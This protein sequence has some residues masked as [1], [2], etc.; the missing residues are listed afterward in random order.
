MTSATTVLVVNML[1]FDATA[2]E[3]LDRVS[4]RLRIV[5]RVG[6]EATTDADIDAEVEGIIGYRPPADLRRTPRLRW[7]QVGSSG[8]DHVDAET[9]SGTR[10]A[11]TNASGVHAVPMGEYV[12]A[13]LLH[14]AQDV[15]PR[16]ANQRARA[17]PEHQ[18]TLAGRLLRGKTLVILGYGSIGREVG[19]LAHGFGMRI[20]AVKSDPSTRVDHGYVYPGTGD[21]EGRYP[22][23]FVGIDALPAV[24][25][26]ADYVVSAL[27]GTAASTGVVSRAVIGAMRP[28]A[29][30][31]NVGRGSAVDEDAL[32]EALRERRIGGSVL[33][34]FRSEPLPAD[35]PL[36]TL[37]RSIVTPHL[38]GG[39]AELPELMIDLVAENLR[40]FASDEPLLNAVDLARGY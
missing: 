24:V 28:T 7:F 3:R 20:I 4:E 39:P 10:V 1:P 30:L 26:E 12:L 15:D 22:E 32:I 18:P 9:L 29:W 5:H 31:V 37:D 38:S 21:P 6:D 8:I 25:G 27:P 19:R 16:Q 17:W 14:I 34:V 33:D 40:R 35:D 2:R 11:V 36:W 13:Y 23:R